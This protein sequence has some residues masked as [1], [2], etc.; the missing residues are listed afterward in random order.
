MNRKQLTIL[1]VASAVLG[2]IGWVVYNKRNSDESSDS[3]G[4]QKVVKSFPMNDVEQISIRQG[5]AQVNL[6]KQ[7]DI[8]TVKERNNYPANF[9]SISE[10]LRKVWE[11]KVAQ[12]VQV[13]Q[14]QLG[15]LELLPPDKGANS[16][17]QV[18][19]KDKGGKNINSLLLGKKH[20]RK[21]SGDESGFGGGGYPDGR[22]IMVGN[23]VQTVAV[24]SD[25]LSNIE[26]KPE[27]WLNKDFFKVENLKSIS[28]TTTNAT[29]NWKLERE[30]ENGEWKL[31]DAK[32]DEQLDSGK[33]GG[34]TGALSSPSFNDV[35]TNSAASATGLDKPMV[36]KLSTF[37]GFNYDVKIGNKTG[38]DNYFFQM[39]V[40]ASLPKER[41][42]GKDEKPEE[43][44]KLDKE[45]KEKN[46]KLQEK[47]KTEK[48][49]EKWIYVVSK[50]TIDPLFKERK[51][52]LAEKKEEPKPETP[53]AATNAVPAP[54]K[55]TELK[56]ATQP[57]PFPPKT[58]IKP[59]PSAPKPESKPAPE[60]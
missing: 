17:T 26:P 16:G 29:N 14:S 37:D 50:W 7:N 38:D 49:Y 51:D 8:W 45:F 36:A 3:R 58:E 55:P 54:P 1:I 13:G 2:V 52:L 12:P 35:A 6:A 32:K 5:S 18:E 41:T 21:G 19:F 56:P 53:P 20:M 46:D 39:A 59:D 24:V 43:K 15:R 48:D 11:M 40:N 23:D 42:A 25:A 47:L 60:K 9:S 28:V 10:F 57:P 30:K 27:E 4:G 44:T 33:S 31:S 22:Y 34:V